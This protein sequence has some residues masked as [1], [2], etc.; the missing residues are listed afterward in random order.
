MLQYH[1]HVLQRHTHVPPYAGA[2]RA[3]VSDLDPSVD[4]RTQ[5]LLINLKPRPYL[6]T[7]DARPWTL[8]PGP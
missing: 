2:R 6:W 7:L 1:T 5:T 4:R 8:D 3:F